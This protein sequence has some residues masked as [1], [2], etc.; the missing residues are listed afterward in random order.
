VLPMADPNDSAPRS[1]AEAN[2]R[3]DKESR[4]ANNGLPS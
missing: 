3:I 4:G 2:R 1:D